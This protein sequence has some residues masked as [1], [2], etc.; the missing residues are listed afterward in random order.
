MI[1]P[2]YQFEVFRYTLGLPDINSLS[3][4]ALRKALRAPKD[5][6]AATF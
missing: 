2:L 5:V 3:E 1:F 4:L 6:E